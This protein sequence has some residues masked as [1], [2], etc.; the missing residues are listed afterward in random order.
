MKSNLVVLT[1]LM[2]VFPIFGIDVR[3]EDGSY[4]QK[5]T[6]KEVVDVWDRFYKCEPD[7]METMWMEKY[8][9]TYSQWRENY[10]NCQECPDTQRLSVW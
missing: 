4:A 7:L 1:V 3:Q 5:P 6:R 10:L 9:T 2:G 8:R